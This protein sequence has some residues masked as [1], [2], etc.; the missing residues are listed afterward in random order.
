VNHVR[1]ALVHDSD[2]TGEALR[3]IVA[4]LG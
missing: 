2:T 1:V 3:R 4:R